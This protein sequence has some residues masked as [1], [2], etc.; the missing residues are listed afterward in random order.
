[1]FSILDHIRI[2]LIRTSHPGNIGSACRAMKTMGVSNLYLVNPETPITDDSYALAAGA[3][4]ILENVKVCSSIAEALRGAK[5]VIGAS[6]RRRTVERP[7]LEPK[8]MAKLVIDEASEDSEIAIIFG[9]ERTGLTNQELEI[10]GY[11]VTISSNPEYASLNL[12]MAVQV[13]TYEIRMAYLNKK[14]PEPISVAPI[15]TSKKYL[16]KEMLAEG[17]EIDGFYNQLEEVLLDSGFLRPNNNG[18][19]MS[20]VKRIFSRPYLTHDDI[21]ILRGILTSV[22]KNMDNK[23]SK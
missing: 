7:L 20:K 4:D 16:E 8:E 11:H 21:N 10:C 22:K 1:M 13:L 9:C 2:V 5:I 23:G 19:I 17:E 18:S 6:A 3:K 12:A 14:G 15:H